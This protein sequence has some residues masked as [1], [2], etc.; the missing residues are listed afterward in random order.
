MTGQLDMAGFVKIYETT[1][2]S[3]EQQALA[4]ADLISCV[5]ANL[6]KP[7]SPVFVRWTQSSI[8]SWINFKYH[9]DFS[10]YDFLFTR[11]KGNQ[12]IDNL[13]TANHV[14]ACDMQSLIKNVIC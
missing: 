13:V 7:S 9:L 10:K 8:I 5:T 6:N 2:L 3:S 14:I 11:L 4:A 12:V 1:S